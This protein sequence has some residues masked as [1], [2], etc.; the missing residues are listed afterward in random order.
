VDS[1]DIAPSTHREHVDPTSRAVVVGAGVLA[2]LHALE[3]LWRG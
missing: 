3:T 1:R 2:C